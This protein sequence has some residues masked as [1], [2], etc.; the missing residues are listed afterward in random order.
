MKLLREE[1]RSRIDLI[2]STV[3][4]EKFG[5]SCTLIFVII[6]LNPDHI[7]CFESVDSTCGV[8]GASLIFPGTNAP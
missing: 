7:S 8:G 3:V 4:P 5:S 2:A 6:Q 1:L